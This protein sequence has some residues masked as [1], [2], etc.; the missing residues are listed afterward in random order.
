[1][2]SAD[3]LILG[4]AQFGLRY[5]VNNSLGKP[6]KNTVFEILSLA[7]DLGIRILDTAEAY[8]D[9]HSLIGEFHNV[10]PNKKFGVITKLPH[11]FSGNL[12]EKIDEYLSDMNIQSL[13]ALLFHSFESYK[14][15]RSTVD[16]INSEMSNHVEYIGVS[17]YTNEQIEYVIEDTA[18]DIIQ[19]PFNLFDNM[20]QRGKLIAKAKQR[21]K[22]LH[23]RSAFLQGMFFMEQL[24]KVTEP[25]WAELKTIRDISKELHIS[26]GTLA[27][28][29]CL[30]Q[31]AIDNVLIGVDTVE[32]LKQNINSIK[33]KIDHKYI[34]K[35][36]SI[37]VKNQD[38]INPS[39]WN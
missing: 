37:L 25:L 3:K 39:K 28:C 36:D 4:T 12:S 26:I 32:Q 14:S 33:T 6:D 17:V 34:T 31:H 5:G 7:Y 10:Y 27:L 9:A 30:Q 38:L 24:T 29:Y 13:K 20:A 2:N 23:T 16:I 22:I 35:I 11:N 15:N 19:L 8:G 18:I 21:N 1:M